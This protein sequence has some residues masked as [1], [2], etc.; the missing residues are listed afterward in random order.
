MGIRDGWFARREDVHELMAAGRRHGVV[1]DNL[2]ATEPGVLLSGR[3]E[4]EVFGHGRWGAGGGGRVCKGGGVM[5]KEG[6]GV[7]EA[8]EKRGYS[9]RALRC[10]HQKGYYS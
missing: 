10:R 4:T 9:T 3:A 1:A 6:G 7:F 5:E 2:F 8:G